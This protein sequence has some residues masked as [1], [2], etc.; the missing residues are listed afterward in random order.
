MLWIIITVGVAVYI[1]GGITIFGVCKY[2]A[3]QKRI[4]EEKEAEE[5][6]RAAEATKREADR[7]KREQ[8]EREMAFWKAE[9]EKQEEERRAKEKAEAEERA[10][11]EEEE[12]KVREEV[13]KKQKEQ[14]KKEELAFQRKVH[15]RWSRNVKPDRFV[16][17]NGA[18]KGRKY[19]LLVRDLNTKVHSVIET[20][21]EDYAEYDALVG[22][23]D[24]CQCMLQTNYN[25]F[26]L[27]VFSTSDWERLF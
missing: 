27:K 19:F 20:T 11:R 14:L 18:H 17:V 4:R 5:K 22:F 8:L 21:K 25:D 10:K 26:R 24:V 2:I 15:A 9:Q 1:I 23:R 3:K 12:R 13:W 7:I 16:V 6:R